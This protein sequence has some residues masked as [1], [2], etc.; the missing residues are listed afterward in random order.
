M[1]DITILLSIITLNHKNL[2]RHLV[3][4]LAN[5][6]YNIGLYEHGGV[7]THINDGFKVTHVMLEDDGEVGACVVATAVD[8][9]LQLRVVAHMDIL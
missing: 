2:A 6:K 5:T 9:L 8:Q 7:S 3:S 1:I 4:E